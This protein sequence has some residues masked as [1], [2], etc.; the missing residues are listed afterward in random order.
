[1]TASDSVDTPSRDTLMRAARGRLNSASRDRVLGRGFTNLLPV[2]AV[3]VPA[4]V[5]VLAG[6]R[7]WTETVTDATAE[8]VRMADAAAETADRA[9]SGYAVAA[10]RV[11]DRL[12][13]LSAEAPPAFERRAH[14]L[15]AQLVEEFNPPVIAFALDAA[16]QPVAA[17]HLFP[18]PTSQSLS[19]RDFFQA[20]SGADRPPVHV[21]RMFVGRFDGRLF[22]AV[23]RGRWSRPDAQGPGRF[24]G[25]VTI[26]VDPNTIGAS[27][28][29]LLPDGTDRI[30]LLRADGLPIASSVLHTEPLTVDP[31]ARAVA[32][33]AAAGGTSAWRWAG[34]DGDGAPGLEALRR[35]EGFPVYAVATR[36]LTAIRAT[37]W[38][39]FGP[40][41]AFGVP[42]IAALLALSLRV[43]RDQ[44][45]LVAANANLLRDVERSE[46]R[47]ERAKRYAMVGTFEVD[48]AT[49]SSVRSPEYMA[50][51]GLAARAARETHADW[52]RRL[53]P[54]DRAGAEARLLK[55]I[56]DDSAASQYE[57]TYRIV[58]ASGEVRWISARGD[59]ERDAQG[60]ARVMRGVHVDVTSL[61]STEA[62]LAETDARLV[63][64]QDAV[65]IGTWEWLPAQGGLYLA[66]RALQLVGYGSGDTTPPWRDVV[67][68]VLPDDRRPLWRALREVL[69]TGSTRVEVRMRAAAEPGAPP[70]QPW[71]IIRAR[72]VE[73]GDGK[74]RRILGVAYDITERKQ[75]ELRASILAKEVEH[76]ARNAMA[77]VSGMV[78]MTTAP[79][80][81][82]FVATLEGRIRSLSQT[83]TLLGRS[84]WSGAAIGELVRAE[85]AAYESDS[86]AGREIR[87]DGPEVMLDVDATQHLS[88]A[89]HELTT[90]SAKYGAL[91]VA[92]GAVEVTWRI[93]GAVVSMIWKERGGPALTSAPTHEGFGTFLIRSTIE[94][95]LGGT[96]EMAWESDGLR[97]NIGFPLPTP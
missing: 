69:A 19:D 55:A 13:E 73:L 37:W 14:A 35:L 8:V 51:H 24:E 79:T 97:C 75:A 9:L 71:V 20:L 28:R 66:P 83:I 3:V 1:M 76:R 84:R 39:A 94:N 70:L 46:D 95:Q 82:E 21:S 15:L 23:S 64:T 78:R 74:G 68:R 44:L 58:T 91:S 81:E 54:D 26:S 49:G 63:L 47:L 77:L 12:A 36:P 34:Q 38:S 93:D 22:F 6:H 7:S 33:L 5:L 41:L 62:Q 48:L 72:A 2:L 30:V 43:R 89:L 96:L 16:G 50:V 67:R 56:A 25:L 80:H 11:N 40:Y 10:A 42:A 32:A 29:R 59:I 90:N 17:S 65:G 88:M 61:R 86:P 53:H 85:L 4:S 52:M 92:H 18:V 27:L 31:G 60:R 57:Q 45:R 87:M